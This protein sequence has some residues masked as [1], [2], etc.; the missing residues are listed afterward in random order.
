VSYIQEKTKDYIALLGP[1]YCPLSRIKNNYRV[2]VILKLTKMAEM[3]RVLSELQSDLQK[4]RE[5]YLEIDFDPLS[6][7]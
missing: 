5:A 3:R 1:A 2:H 6:M 7:L 4:K